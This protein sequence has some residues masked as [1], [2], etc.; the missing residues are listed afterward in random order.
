MKVLFDTNIIIDILK[1]DPCFFLDSFAS[2]DVCVLRGWEPF[3]AVTA[4]PDIEYL[5]TA[6]KILPK[7]QVAQ[8]MDSLLEMFSVADA[9]ECDCILARQSEM[10]DLEDGILAYSAHRNGVD[11]IVTRNSKDFVKSPAPALTP[12]DFV[13]AYKPS[14]INYDS[15][16]I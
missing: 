13:A 14:D 9:Q 2:Y 7:S 6:R 11:T 15:A 10:P 8:A 3:I 5:L 16:G 4:V 1:K 12:A